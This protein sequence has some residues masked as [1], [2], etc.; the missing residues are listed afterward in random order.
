MMNVRSFRQ[1]EDTSGCKHKFVAG[2]QRRM[3]P[4]LLA[5]FCDLCTREVAVELDKNDERTGRSWLIECTDHDELDHARLKNQIVD[6]D[7][8]RNADD[9]LLTHETTD[10][11]SLEDTHE[12][13]P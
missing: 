4:D 11:L 1:I 6:K 7:G 12:D 9:D 3:Q 13:L 2:P 5:G 8:I 10:D